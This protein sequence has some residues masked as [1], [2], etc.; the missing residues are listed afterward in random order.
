MPHLLHFWHNEDF[1]QKIGS[2]I[3]MSLLNS[4]LMQKNQKKNKQTEQNSGVFARTMDPKFTR[5]HFDL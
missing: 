2:I 5:D 1:P 3:F 4:K